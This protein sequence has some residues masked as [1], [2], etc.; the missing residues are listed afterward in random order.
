MTLTH[1]LTHSLTQS[2]IRAAAADAGDAPAASASAAAGSACSI[3]VLSTA[4]THIGSWAFC[5]NRI[6]TAYTAPQFQPQFGSSG[7]AGPMLIGTISVL[8]T[9]AS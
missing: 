7:R 4:L 6:I 1:S 8:N 9:V 3:L 5:F 2:G